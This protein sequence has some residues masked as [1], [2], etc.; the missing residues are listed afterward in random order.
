MTAALTRIDQADVWGAQRSVTGAIVVAL[1][2]ALQASWGALAS[3]SALLMTVSAAA[4]L[5]WQCLQMGSGA[6][7]GRRPALL[8]MQI[9]FLAGVTVLASAAA[10][11]SWRPRSLDPSATSVDVIVILGFGCLFML[12]A[13]IAAT[14]RAAVRTIRWLVIGGAVFAAWAIWAME[15]GMDSA[16]FAGRLAATY[17]TANTAGLVFA[18]LLLLAVYEIMQGLRRTFAG[19]GGWALLAGWIGVACVLAT[20]LMLTA[21][22]GAIA[23]FAAA[24]IVLLISQWLRSGAMNRIALGGVTIVVL[25]V[26]VAF[27]GAFVERLFTAPADAAIRGELF[28]LHWGVFLERPLWGHGLGT[29][30]ILN[31][32]HLTADTFPRLWMMRAAHNLYLQWLEEAG[33]LGALCMGSTLLTAIGLCV[34]GAIRRKVS[35]SLLW[36][37]FGVDLIFLIHGV[38]DFGLQTP[39]VAALFALLL[40]LQV[41]LALRPSQDPSDQ[42]RRAPILAVLGLAVAVL[43]AT[44]LASLLAGGAVVV[45][46]QRIIP[47][48]AGYDRLAVRLIEGGRDPARL[49]AARRA[50]LAAIQ[51]SPYNT[52]GVLRL[53]Y[54]DTLEQG[55][56]TPT[57][58]AQLRRSYQLIPLDQSVAVWRI[59]FALE[60]WGQVDPATR[61]QVKREFD[62]LLSTGQYRKVLVAMLESIRNPEGAFVAAFWESQVW[63]SG[64]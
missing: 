12:G 50:T 35:S 54:I 27:G 58:A 23:A 24:F 39:S 63:L 51:D 34:V 29:F 20:A 8:A 46:G 41:G 38:S 17:H 32:T 28:A 7:V 60:N 64:K 3:E 42:L 48:S 49:A 33:V 56:L 47:V 52:S 18:V 40:G 37:L 1:L 55:R 22:R 2:L 11:W 61:I 36:A 6:A 16:I 26:G 5:A 25:A 15:A 44:A 10:P 53:A 21:S 62:A 43:G 31:R 13:I 30:D 9:V 19:G 4:L 59:R 14:H 57:G 45:A